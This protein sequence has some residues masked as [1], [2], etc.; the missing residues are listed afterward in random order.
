VKNGIDQGGNGGN[1]N[2][3]ALD[4]EWLWPTVIGVVVVL[5]T[6][7]VCFVT[8]AKGTRKKRNFMEEAE[9]MLIVIL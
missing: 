4:L 6:L 8:P 1:G 3:A 9:N 7:L 2:N 5:V